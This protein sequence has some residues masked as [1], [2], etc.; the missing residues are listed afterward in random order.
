[1]IPLLVEPAEDPALR[2]V[3]HGSWTTDIGNRAFL[4]AKSFGSARQIT[5]A[6]NEQLAVGGRRS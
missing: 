4:E 6:L 2:V 1:M 5:T 3:F